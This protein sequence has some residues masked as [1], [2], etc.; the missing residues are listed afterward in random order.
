MRSRL[1]VAAA[2]CC[3]W[4]GAALCQA[5][6]VED[7]SR[8]RERFEAPISPRTT[9]LGTISIPGLGEPDEKL[10]SLSLKISSITVSG[11]SAIS[12]SAIE[13]LTGSLNGRQLIIAAVY[14]AAGFSASS[15]GERDQRHGF[16][17]NR[18]Q[19]HLG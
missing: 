6:R 15:A 18:T 8:I 19:R 9:D 12:P 5:P 11:A 2:F 10:R 3:L 4:G 1:W 14:E 16:A 7:P 13:P 17:R